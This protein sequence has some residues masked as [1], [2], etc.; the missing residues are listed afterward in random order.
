LFLTRYKEEEN[1][2]LKIHSFFLKIS[3]IIITLNL[4]DG[5]VGLVYE[6]WATYSYEKLQ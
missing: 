6:T 5:E 4:A 1:I 3:R 2:N